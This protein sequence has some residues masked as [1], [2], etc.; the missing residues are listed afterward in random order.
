MELQALAVFCGYRDGSD[1]AY[2]EAAIKLGSALVE[3]DI[4]LVYG[5]GAFGMMGALANT[6]LEGGG[7]AV[8][9]IP[10]F[11]ME[12]GQ[13]HPGL[14]E[15]HV[16]DSLHERKA[17]MAEISDGFLV[18][19]G[20][21]GTLDELFEA[22]T[23]MQLGVHDKPI[24]LVNTKGYYDPLIAFMDRALAQEF[25]TRDHH[26]LLMMDREVS[27]VLDAM[28]ERLAGLDSEI[29]RTRLD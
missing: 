22:L 27:A 8:G 21:L 26:D 2:V 28:S 19:P 20:G 3:R 12:R 4:T 6:V 18:L 11:L 24:G 13:G 16:V 17:R 9:V 10:G 25:M 15:V 29:V 5:G 1:P 14:K 23:S 7:R